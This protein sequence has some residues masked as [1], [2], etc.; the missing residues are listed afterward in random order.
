MS[1]IKHI[2]DRLS[3]KVPK[4]HKRSSKWGKVR[5][6]HLTKQPNCAV[7]GSLKKTE[8]HHI[9]P[10]HLKPE[11][12]LDPGNLIT[13]CES[14]NNGICCHLLVGHLGNYKKENPDVK[15]DAK[16][17]SKKLNKNNNLE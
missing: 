3:G 5:L 11:L 8:V 2:K 15:K 12:E 1:L 17:W 16:Q 9:Q 10:F 7:C 6:E 13:L 4:G 14:W